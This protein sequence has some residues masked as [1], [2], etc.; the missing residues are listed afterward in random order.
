MIQ[1][2]LAIS[3]LFLLA[4][5]APYAKDI[6]V[7][8]EVEINADISLY[9]NYNWLNIITS[10]N[11]PSGEWQPPGFDISNDIR[12]LIDRELDKRGVHYNTTSPELAVS[13]K[14]N[15][16][17]QALK[18]VKAPKSKQGILINKPDATLMVMLIDVA[19]KNIIW[20]SKADAEIQ[21]N[22]D[23][24]LVRK[25]LDYTITEMFKALD[26]KSWF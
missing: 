14:I 5:C 9:Q 24:E 18:L 21:E 19:S 8:T 23:A 2:L 17:M 15:V 25:R 10:L 26:K 16:N 3:L 11:D 13:F 4:G 12:L 6:K 22:I 20:I 1:R 7:S